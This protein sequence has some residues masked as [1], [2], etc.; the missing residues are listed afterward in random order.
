MTKTKNKRRT[1]WRKRRL[2]EGFCY[3]CGTRPHR[4]NMTTC[5]R[6]ASK[7]RELK[8]KY[9]N[10]HK[11]AGLCHQCGQPAV[12]GK[13]RCKECTTLANTRGKA[14]LAALRNECLEAYGGKCQW[15][16]EAD[17]RLLTFDHVHNDGAEQ[18]KD[19]KGPNS[20]L[21]WLRRNKYPKSIQILCYNCNCAKQYSGYKGPTPELF[22]EGLG[23]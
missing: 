22:T 23:I 7:S 5:E 12:E 13:M 14:R 4:P 6:C 18:R 19:L 1:E 10:Q 17:R 20:F 11:K 3:N 21:Y 9:Y 15:C 2:S 16:G 8:R